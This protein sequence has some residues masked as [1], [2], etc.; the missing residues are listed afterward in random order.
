[1]WS[2]TYRDLMREHYG[3][4]IGIHSY[5]P[6]LFPGGLPEGT[7]IGNYCSLADGI[8]VFRR[9]HPTNRFSQH[10]FFFNSA[11]GLVTDDTIDAVCDHPLVVGDDVWIGAN[12]IVTPR[13]SSIGLGA[14]VA[15]G[16]V[17]TKDVPPFTIVGGNP[18]HRIAERFSAEIQRVLVE[19][20]WW[21]YPLDRLVPFVPLFLEDATLENAQRLRDHLRTQPV[22]K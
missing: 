12:A 16:A 10:P 19:S 13:C 2:T 1:M 11:S 9:N 22:P 4:E 20:C 21:K 15:A 17:V 18:A 6:S 8:E 3:V 14:V 5:G 7:R